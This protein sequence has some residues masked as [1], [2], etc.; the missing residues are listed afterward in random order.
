MR[1]EVAYS[2]GLVQGGTVSQP[3]QSEL[4]FLEDG[5]GKEKKKNE[6]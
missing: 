5:R 3:A 2:S 4:P 6:E 1:V